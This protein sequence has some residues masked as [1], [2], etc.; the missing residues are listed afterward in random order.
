MRLAIA[1]ALLTSVAASAETRDWKNKDASR[2]VRGDFISR[3]KT[4][5]L[6]RRSS[7]LKQTSLPLD[8]M[9]VSDLAWLEKTHPIPKPK[10]PAPT[11]P[12]GLLKSIH[13]TLSYGDN[14]S[15]VAAKLKASGIFDSTMPDSF[16]A[17]T[18]MDG[19][20]RT[21]QKIAN[22]YSVLY[23][24]WNED[25]G[26]KDFTLHTDSLQL[27]N[28]KD[29]ILPCWQYYINIITE[30]YGKPLNA[31]PTLELGSIQQDAIIF[32][33]LWQTEQMGSILIGASHNAD[34][35]QIAMRFSGESFKP[36]IKTTPTP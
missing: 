3:D 25:G 10:P 16:L 15:K 28:A 7:D 19:I 4:S 20:F 35:Y 9:H 13:G 1:I 33:H 27:S 22:Q 2:S 18:G 8:Q 21:K 14:S 17:R 34:G 29:Q 32:T 23:F 11:D 12:K 31:N 5:V 36:K 30:L 26:L 6:I 24:N